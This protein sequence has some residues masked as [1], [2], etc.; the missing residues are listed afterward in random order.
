MTCERDPIDELAEQFVELWR[1][2]EHPSVASWAHAYPVHSDT[3]RRLFP[4]LIAIE[5]LKSPLLPQSPACVSPGDSLPERIGDCRIVR[6][7]GRGGMGVVYEAVQEPPGRRVAVKV[8]PSWIASN[9]NH[10]QRF[11]R[12]S[13]NTAKL[14]HPHIVSVFGAGNEKGTPYFV[15]QHIPGVGL[16]EVL[17]A[18]RNRLKFRDDSDP[19]F[20]STNRP[21]PVNRPSS[22]LLEVIVNRWCCDSSKGKAHR[23]RISW[24]SAARVAIQVADALHYA[25]GKKIIHRDVKPGNLLIDSTGA[26]W[27]T[28]FG[29]AKSL[30]ASGSCSGGDIVGT[31]RYMAPEQFRGE[32]DPRCDVYSLGITLYEMLT[33]SPAFAA[34]DV[35]DLVKAIANSTPCLPSLV[36]PDIPPELEAIVVKATAS[37]PQ[38]R[39][40]SAGMLANELQHFLHTCK[41]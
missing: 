2:G 23:E 22:D 37:D 8:L 41:S 27:V 30:S 13:R 24:R 6:E 19:A 5:S 7:I 39:H 28:D 35:M 33:L 38:R 36:Q 17:A 11:L 18:M 10:L 1:R 40:S 15:M 32:C 12:E 9:K 16:D 21:D 3:I 31:M 29:L 26:P 14:H 4:T 34:S 25:H 20:S